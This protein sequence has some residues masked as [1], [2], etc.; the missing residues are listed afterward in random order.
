[1][2]S[3]RSFPFTSGS[4]APKRGPELPLDQDF[5][6]DDI[7]RAIEPD[8]R[9][10]LEAIGEICG[11]SKLSLANEY[12]SHIAPLG[13]IRAPPGGLLTVEE[14]SSDHER[15]PDDAVLIFDDDS[16]SVIGARDYA[17]VPHYRY[18]EHI[19]PPAGSPSAMVYHSFAPFSLAE[20]SGLLT[21]SDTPQALLAINSPDPI[22]D[23]LPTTREFASKPNSSGRTLLA[24]KHESAKDDQIKSILTP[25]LVAEILLDA[26]SSSQP[27]AGEDA[28]DGGRLDKASV[29]AD[30]Q[31]LF[32][33]L[34]SA[35]DGQPR[36]A[37]KLLREMLERQHAPANAC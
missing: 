10:T 34:R 23:S 19:G 13:E 2:P 33:W 17:S 11:R 8:L 9:S 16:T 28:D 6:I 24:E 29:L 31:A 1:M 3:R 26:Q 22:A 4:R 7:L 5:S 18:L 25:A 27:R 12:G 37:E 21:Q 36:S 32:K 15:H 30:V 35:S 14:A 20:G